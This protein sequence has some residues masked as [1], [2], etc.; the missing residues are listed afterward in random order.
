MADGIVLRLRRPDL[1]VFKTIDEVGRRPI[2]HVAGR[3][4]AAICP[5][6]RRP[7]FGAFGTGRRRD[8][9]GENG[10]GDPCD[11]RAKVRLRARGLPAANLRRAL[12]RDRAW[13]GEHESTVVL[14]G[15]RPGTSDEGCGEGSR[16]A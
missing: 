7:S 5:S 12:L 15:S 4:P 10:G 3:Q 2:V 16:R 6:C 13:R 8:R 1:N 11:L 9:C 14:R